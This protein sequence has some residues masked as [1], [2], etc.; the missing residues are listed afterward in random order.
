MVKD[1][2]KKG[3]RVV[4][5]TNFH[6]KGVKGILNDWK[7]RKE[8]KTFT[9]DIKP[10]NKVGLLFLGKKGDFTLEKAHDETEQG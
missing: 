1:K 5:F 4:L 9:I 2:I 8:T 3:D 7:Y 6:R 10:D